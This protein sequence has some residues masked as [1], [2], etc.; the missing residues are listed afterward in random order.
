MSLHII[1]KNENLIIKSQ[2]MAKKARVW[3][4]PY[5]RAWNDTTGCTKRKIGSVPKARGGNY[6][7]KNEKNIWKQAVPVLETNPV[8]L[9]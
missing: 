3:Q 2:G 7:N 1:Q 4:L 8:W 5:P 9:L 6:N